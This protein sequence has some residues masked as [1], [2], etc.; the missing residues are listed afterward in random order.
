MVSLIKSSFEL[1]EQVTQLHLPD[2]CRVFTAN[3]FSMY[4]NIRTDVALR[5][6]T[7]Y[8]WTN[9]EKFPG[10]PME[11]LLAAL[12]LIMKHNVFK[13]GDTTWL[14]VSGTAMG[15]PPTPAYATIYYVIH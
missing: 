5:C 15:I 9:Q 8:L 12:R 7:I 1:K 14:Q 13:F 2:N 11:A 6:I 10:I 4:I 3:I